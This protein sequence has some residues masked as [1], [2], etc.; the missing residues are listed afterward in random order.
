MKGRFFRL[1]ALTLTIALAGLLMATTATA[2]GIINKNNQSA[3]Y[4]RTLSRHA[5]TDYADYRG[6][7]SRGDHADGRW[8]LRQ[9]GRHCITP[10][11]IPTTCRAMVN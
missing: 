3:D 4:I 1:S 7:Q 6:L 11:I 5:A 2:G 9:T 10:R 8:V